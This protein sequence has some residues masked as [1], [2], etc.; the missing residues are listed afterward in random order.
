MKL[1]IMSVLS[2][3]SALLLVFVAF[4]A[5]S[6]LSRSDDARQQQ[7]RWPR[8]R[9]QQQERLAVCRPQAGQ[10]LATLALDDNILQ[11]AL[12]DSNGKLLARHGRRACRPGR[13]RR[14]TAGAASR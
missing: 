7:R 6:V 13:P 4:A 12:Y 8:N 5:T 1:T 2:A 3:G 14:R 9:P 10:A 11:A